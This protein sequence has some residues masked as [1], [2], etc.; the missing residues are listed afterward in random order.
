M[1]NKRSIIHI[2]IFAGIVSASD[3]PHDEN[4]IHDMTVFVFQLG[5]II[6]LAKISGM[7]FEKFRMPG[8]LGEITIGIISGPYL[9]GS[10]PLPSLGFENGLFPLSEGFIP[11]SKELYGI[12]IIASILLLFISGLETDLKLLLRYLLSGGVVGIG[13]VVFSFI[14]GALIGMYFLDKPFISP[15][16]L[17]LGIMSTATSVGITAMILSKNKYMESPEGVTIL[18]A[19]IIDD[20]L[21]IIILSI[22]MGVA[23]VMTNGGTIHWG[24]ITYISIR[25]LIVWLGITILGLVSANRI[26]SL[27]KIFGNKYVYSVIA[28][29]MALFLAGIFEKA[30]LAMIIGAYIMGLTLSKTDISYEIQE[31]IHPIKELL[32]PVFFVVMGML[33]DIRSITLGTLTFAVV[34]S[35]VAL[36][37][38]IFGCGI[39]AMFTGFNKKGA[40]RIGLGMMP[41]GEVGLIIAGI[42]LSNGFIDQ[43]IYGVAIM[44][45]L[46]GII[47][48][49]SLLNYALNT[50]GK[51]TKRELKEDEMGSY[52]IQMENSEQA[53]ILTNTIIEYFEK[54]GYY[55][56]R[57]VLEYDVYQIRKEDMFIKLIKETKNEHSDT[58][59]FI[60]KK[61]DIEFVKELVFEAS[62]K[63]EYNSTS[64]LKRL[65]LREMKK[66]S[67]TN[68]KENIK[69]NFDISKILDPECIVTD[70]KAEKKEAAVKELIDILQAKGKISDKEA[71]FNEVMLRESIISTG[72]SHGVAVPHARTEGIDCVQIA[73]GIKRSGIDFDAIDSHPS[74]IIFL[75]VSSTKKNDPHI[76]ILASISAYF[77]REDFVNEFLLL[78][79]KDDIYNYFKLNRD[80]KGIL[81]KLSKRTITDNK[82][83][84]KKGEK[85]GFQ[86]R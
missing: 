43:N 5:S 75:L 13:G 29:G 73:L 34:Y 10:V 19:A 83:K 69:I 62:V 6:F 46:L 77:Y 22:V 65:D 26:S 54:E 51:G 56:T 1:I 25:A 38:K 48:T 27:L 32:V 79:T 72:M 68:S 15:E 74:K 11:I 36:L 42:G 18:S 57:L 78:E 45:V 49:P 66:N 9:L 63:L 52:E 71:I 81:N 37:T 14:P 58:I 86:H 31:A 8:T 28:L 4:I 76:K 16:C 60:T 59:I 39:P 7:I 50:K 84:T 47:A 44:M 33:V 41:R 23:V 3:Q 21:G 67:K 82:S 17:F 12:S 70:L 35:V 53:E 24:H 20:V 85:Y 80:K 30:G 2:L 55:I 64:I 61:E 40:I